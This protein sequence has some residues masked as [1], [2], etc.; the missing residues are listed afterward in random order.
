MRNDLVA[1]GVS[2]VMGVAFSSAT[3]KNQDAGMGILKISHPAFPASIR[4]N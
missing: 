4:G 3:D 1:S 2:R